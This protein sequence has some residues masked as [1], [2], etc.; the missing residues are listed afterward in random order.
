[1]ELSIVNKKNIIFNEKFNYNNA[2]VIAQVFI[3]NSKSKKP[4]ESHLMVFLLNNLIFP[5]RKSYKKDIFISRE[6]S[7]CF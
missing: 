5:T 7:L 6:V 3:D 1:M 4:L 2:N